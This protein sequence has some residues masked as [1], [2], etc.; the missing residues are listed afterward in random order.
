MLHDRFGEALT[1]SAIWD[2]SLL[3]SARCDRDHG[4][5]LL[6]SRSKFRDNWRYFLDQIEAFTAGIYR[7][8]IISEYGYPLI[9][10]PLNDP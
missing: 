5:L 8:L 7:T 9:D 4:L 6:K 10:S 1:Y 2:R 3:V